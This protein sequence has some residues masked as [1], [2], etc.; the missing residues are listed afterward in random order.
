MRWCRDAAGIRIHGTTCARPVQ[1]FTA[2]EQPKLLAYAGCYDVPVFKT[3]KGHRDFH[4]E[5]AKALYSLPEQWIGTA[6]DVRADSELVKFYR[7]GV[8]VK[9]HPRQPAGGRSTDPADLPEHKTGYALRDVAALIAT[10]AAHGPNVGIYA[11]R[12]LD[13]RL[14]WTRMRTVYRLLGLV[15][16]YGTPRVEAACA[17]ALDLDV[18]SVT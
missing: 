3:V 8:L 13:D 14:P 9:V 15:R 5:V 1:M 16:R 10:C 7:R 6:L 18:V 2:E 11:E 17:L 4:A 12:I